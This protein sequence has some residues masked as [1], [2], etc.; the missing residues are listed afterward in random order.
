[1]VWGNERV[2]APTNLLKLLVGH[3][4]CE[5]DDLGLP[6]RLG[7]VQLGNECLIS[8][9]CEFMPGVSRFVL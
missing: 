4:M 1:M 8:S 5:E 2:K 7:L 9:I 6:T 3:R